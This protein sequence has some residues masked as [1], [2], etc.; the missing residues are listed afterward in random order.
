[1]SDFPD[2]KF[3]A[4]Q[5]R[6]IAVV[7][8]KTPA[9]KCAAARTLSAYWSEIS[10][11]SSW[12]LSDLIAP[13]DHP[14]RPDRP[15]LVAPKAL[16]RR[17]LGSM[18]GRAALMHAIAHI[19]FNA[20]NLAADMVARFGGDL[21]ILPGER[22]AFLGDWI[23]VCADEARHFQMVAARLSA[24]DC[25]YGD[26]PAHNGLWEAAHST[27]LD[28]AARLVIA[29]MVL[30][31]RGL[32][33]SPGM[34]EKLRGH[35][36]DKSADILQQIYDEEIAH[37]RAGAHWFHRLCATENQNPESY[38]KALL[39]QHFSA[40]LKPPFNKLARAA[41]GIPDRYYQNETETV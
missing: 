3:A 17:R 1:M 27:R 41:A 7:R 5:A 31:A 40:G 30:E 13:P 36:D 21:R 24:L 15:A 28:L 20:I 10:G 8:A 22:T 19:E 35:G 9:D 18:A 25:A 11:A 14:G 12:D 26:L 23:G 29:P 6:A 33:V 39:S 38:F 34:I 16:K 37:V 2:T 4:L 32:D